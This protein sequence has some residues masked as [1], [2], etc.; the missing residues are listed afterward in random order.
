M[1]IRGLIW[2]ARPAVRVGAQTDRRGDLSIADLFGNGADGTADNTLGDG[3]RTVSITL[4][5]PLRRERAMYR[6]AT[7]RARA[8]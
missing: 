1:T 2:G 5:A 6:R 4:G 8:E 7:G 3:E